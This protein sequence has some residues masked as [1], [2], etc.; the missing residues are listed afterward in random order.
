MIMLVLYLRSKVC[1]FVVKIN[2]PRNLQHE[3]ERLLEAGWMHVGASYACPR[4]SQM[5]GVFICSQSTPWRLLL[6][7]RSG[8]IFNIRS[9][10]KWTWWSFSFEIGCSEFM[11]L[12]KSSNVK[13]VSLIYFSFFAWLGGRNPGILR[14]IKPE[15][16]VL[17]IFLSFFCLGWANQGFWGT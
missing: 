17:M 15:K 10:R 16:M 13:L 11:Y 3:W 14:Y 4:T 7:S 8:R 5:Q 12:A 2:K 6:A 9:C 1:A